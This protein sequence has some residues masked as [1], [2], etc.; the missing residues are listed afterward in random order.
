MRDGVA[1]C[2]FNAQQPAYGNLQNFCQLAEF[3][4][5]DEPRAD[6]NAGDAVAL[7]DDARYL[8]LCRQIALRQ[9]VLAPRLVRAVDIL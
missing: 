7:D 1:V 4:I 2:S 5:S 9:S 6:L 8:Q 3:V